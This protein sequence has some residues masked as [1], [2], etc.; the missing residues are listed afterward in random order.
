[1]VY[2]FSPIM[3]QFSD[4]EQQ[5]LLPPPPPAPKSNTLLYVGILV[6]VAVVVILLIVYFTTPKPAGTGTA[7][8]TRTGT[9]TSATTSTGTRTGTGTTTGTSTGTTSIGTGTATGTSTNPC[10]GNPCGANGTC[11][12]TGTY[13]TCN[14]SAGYVGKPCVPIWTGTLSTLPGA[15]NH[16]I[17]L[18]DESGQLLSRCNGC[19]PNSTIADI[20][21]VENLSP[22]FNSSQWYVEDAGAGRFSFKSDNGKYLARC[23]GCVT[24]NNPGDTGNDIAA[25]HI[26]FQTDGYAAWTVYAVNGKIALQCDNGTFLTRCNG[27]ANLYTG[28]SNIALLHETSGDNGYAQWT[29]EVKS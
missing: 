22:D 23:N 29:Y 3:D 19:A 5:A 20:A 10:A 24:M 7:A 18:R 25:P 14:C 26:A 27:C 9:S 15:L 2:H 16:Y 11:V 6:T 21:V 1:M 4:E 12:V 17:V 28:V 13:A 8:G